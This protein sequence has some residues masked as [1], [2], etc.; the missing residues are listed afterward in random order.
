MTAVLWA[1]FPFGPAFLRTLF[2][3][4]GGLV[5]LIVRVAQYHVGIRTSSSVFHTVAQSLVQ[6]QT[7][8]TL[9]WY[10]VSS[11][12]FCLPLLSSY[13]ANTDF[14]WIVYRNGDR[15]RLNEKPLFLTTYLLTCA[16]GQ[17]AGHVITDVD[18]LIL[19]RP[20]NKAGDGNEKDNVPGPLGRVLADI[21]CIFATSIT[22]AATAVVLHIVVYYGLLRSF[23]WGWTLFFLRPFYSL[24]KTNMLPPS[25]P[26]TFSS[27]KTCLVSGTLVFFLWKA[28]NVAFLTFMA[29]KPLKNG[30]PLTAESKDPNGSLLNG[31]KSKKQYIRVS[32]AHHTE[33]GIGADVGRPLPCGSWRTSRATSRIAARPSSRTLIARKARC[34][35]RCTPFL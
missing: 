30:K 10:A 1:W 20:E 19:R 16:V 8:W 13:S 14:H 11:A 3:S 6:P 24:P 22:W 4:L 28:S 34:G 32:E 23:T 18:K 7:Y 12:A 31:L 33:Q 35:P 5:I 2:L 17:A 9:L 21:P 15:A 27:L 25:G 29:R 26:A